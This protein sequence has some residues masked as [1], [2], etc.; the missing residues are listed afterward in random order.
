MVLSIPKINL[1]IFKRN[2]QGKETLNIEETYNL[3]LL[4]TSRYNHVESIQIMANFIHDR[5]LL[6]AANRLMADYQ[7]QAAD[8]EREARFF[9]IKMP[10]KPPFDGKTSTKVDII[11]DQYVY[12]SLLT[13]LKADLFTLN[14]TVRTSTTNDR[15]R[16]MLREMLTTQVNN[17]D[18]FIKYSKVK[19][20]LEIGPTYKTSGDTKREKLDV[21]EAYHLWDHLSLRYDQIQLTQFFASFAHDHEY[22]AILNSGLQ[23]LHKQAGELEKLLLEFEIPMTKRPPESLKSP[24]DPE[25]LEDVFSFRNVLRGIQESLD[26]HLRAIV[27]CTRNDNLRKLFTTFLADEHKVYDKLLKYGKAKGW[28][29]IPPIYTE[30]V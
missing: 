4:L 20:W 13:T 21:G 14:R 3:W 28:I 18:T 5:D 8:L 23:L 11:T 19:E 9:V 27:Q 16:I 7:K 26:L 30:P 2:S 17:H 10:E 24:I 25:T 29:N 15:F 12:T 22:T 1:P 6:L